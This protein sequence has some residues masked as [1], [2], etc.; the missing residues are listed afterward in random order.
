VTRIIKD[1]RIAVNEILKGNVI[2]LPTE[3]VYGL[4][5]DALNSNAVIKIFEVKQRPRFNPLIVHVHSVSELEKYAK[6]IPADVYKIADKFSPG[7]VTFI[8]KKKN[9]IP[10]IVTAGLDS[11]AIRI[12]DHPLFLKVLKNSGRPVAAPSANIFGRISPTN[13]DEVYKELKGKINYILNGGRSK[14]G[15]ESTIISFLDGNIT[16]FRPGFVTTDEIK[17]I[18]GKIVVSRKYNGKIL[19]PGMLKSHYAPETPLYI[20]SDSYFEG[21]KTI[22]GAGILDL[23]KYNNLNT[24]ASKLFSELR[25]LDEKNYNFMI[26]IRVPDIGIGI[27]INDRLER[28]SKGTVKIDVDLLKFKDK[29]K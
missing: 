5:A 27:A 14:V 26:A 12:P 7:P 10:D 18:T 17:K 16:I 20:T 22:L 3:T 23:T 29:K 2:G 19:S 11:V 25:K 6:N 15:I 28:A 13:A 8:L 21:R 4:G 24:A 1:T 9:I